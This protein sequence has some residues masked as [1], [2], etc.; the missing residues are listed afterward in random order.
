MVLRLDVDERDAV[1]NQIYETTVGQPLEQWI[2]RGFDYRVVAG[3]PASSA[4]Y[5][6][7]SQR[8]TNVQMPP[9]ATEHTDPTGMALIQAWIESL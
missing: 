2:G 7:I 5:Y 9:L 6:R 1:Q 8:V 3:D 4:L